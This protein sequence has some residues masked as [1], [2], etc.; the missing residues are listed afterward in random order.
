MIISILCKIL[1]MKNLITGI[2]CLIVVFGLFYPSR[3][4]LVP[5]EVGN[6]AHLFIFS[7]P[8]FWVL[9]GYNFPKSLVLTGFIGAAILSEYCQKWFCQGRGF[10]VMDIALD[11]LGIVIAFFIN[12]VI[13]HFK[14]KKLITLFLLGAFALTASAQCPTAPNCPLAVEIT[15][16]TAVEKNGVVNLT[17]ATASEVNA[18]SFTIERSADGVSFQK[19][20][21]IAAQNKPSIYHFADDAP[22]SI[23]AYYRLV[24]V[25]F[26]GK[27]SVFKAIFVEKATQLLTV[28]PNPSTGVFTVSK[29]NYLIY[30][31]LGRVVDGD[32]LPNGIYFIKSGLETVRLIIQ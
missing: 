29:R 24:E 10:E 6:W 17:W 20:G 18:A 26:S 7:L 25:D 22:L 2:V 1:D 8:M 16:F 32:K 5:H 27:P 12:L 15:S 13:N 21:S 3:W 19:I 4:F 31:I 9:R 11:C 23:G 28:Y 30:N 14:M